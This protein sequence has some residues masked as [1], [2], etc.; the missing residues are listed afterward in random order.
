MQIGALECLVNILHIVSA[1][2]IIILDR[3][4]VTLLLLTTATE[5]SLGGS[6]P[7]TSTEKINKR[8]TPT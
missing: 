2:N 3:D 8:Y 1:E 5:L 6:G 4:S 7:Y